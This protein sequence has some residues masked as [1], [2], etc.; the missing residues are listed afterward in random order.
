[1][2]QVLLVSIIEIA[3]EEEDYLELNEKVKKGEELLKGGN[4]K[5]INIVGTQEELLKKT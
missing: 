3:D 2:K 4:R 5:I 1:M